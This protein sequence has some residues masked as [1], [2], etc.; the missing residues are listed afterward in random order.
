MDELQLIYGM[1]RK[2][3][4][5]TTKHL[6][7]NKFTMDIYETRSKQS[8]LTDFTMLLF[9]HIYNSTHYVER[10]MILQFLLLRI[11]PY[12]EIFYE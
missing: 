3:N 11:E 8:V 9:V 7:Q 2:L 5:Q 1:R 12:F 6:S 10:V 4:D